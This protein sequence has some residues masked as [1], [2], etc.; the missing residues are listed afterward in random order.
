MK[1]GK[2]N[3][4]IDGQWGSTGKGKT[5]NNFMSTA[6][7]ARV[8][9][10]A[11]IKKINRDDFFQWFDGRGFWSWFSPEKEISGCNNNG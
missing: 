6:K 1:K 4:L 8:E 5:Y 9:H 11:F 7:Q 3:I 2:V 10:A